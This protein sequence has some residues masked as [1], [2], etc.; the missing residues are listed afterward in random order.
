MTDLIKPLKVVRRV[1]LEAFHVEP[2]VAF[3]RASL[4]R[5]LV[6]TALA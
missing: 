6:A 1:S 4:D 3:K 5:A 2:A